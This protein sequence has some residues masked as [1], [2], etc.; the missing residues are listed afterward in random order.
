MHYKKWILAVLLSMPAMTYVQAQ[1]APINITTTAVPFLRIPSDARAGGMGDLSLATSPDANSSLLNLAKTPFAGS[2]SAIGV[3]YTPWMKDVASSVYLATLAGYHRLDDE[4][5]I[6]ASI[7][8]FNMGDLQ[9]TDYSGNK[10]QTAKP[11]EFAV[12]LGYSRKL[13]RVFSMGVAIRY[14]N[15]S[16]ASGEY[17]GNNY[18]AGSAVAGDLSFYYHGLNSQGTGFTAGL[19][20]TNLGSKM[21]Y[22]NDANTKDFIPANLGLGIAYTSAFNEVNSITIGAEINKLLVPA[23]PA[24]SSGL[25]GY[26]HTGV[27]DSW[28]KS[29]KTSNYQ[30]GIGAEYVYDKLLSLRT[31]YHFADKNKGGQ[32]YF[33]AGAGLQ[34]KQVGINFSYLAASGNGVTRNPLSNTLRFGVNFNAGHTGTVSK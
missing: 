11:R 19:A 18:K 33:T 5:A 2:K 10:L 20:L 29:F 8:Y 14:I 7:R 4:Q 21:G 32:N 16:L 12:D 23:V 31:G 22:T 13:S 27:F 25:A 1:T 17:N 6:A 34:W 3:T 30:F 28:F 15:S 26:Y 9:L 24:D